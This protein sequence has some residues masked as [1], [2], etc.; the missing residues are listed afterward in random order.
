MLKSSSK[1]SI[2]LFSVTICGNGSWRLKRK[3][4]FN[5]IPINTARLL[6]FKKKTD[7]FSFSNAVPT[8]FKRCDSRIVTFPFGWHWKC[9][10][11]TAIQY[12][13]WTIGT[14]SMLNGNFRY[15]LAFTQRS[16]LKTLWPCSLCMS[17]FGAFK[18][19]FPSH[20]QR[21]AAQTN[22]SLLNI[23]FSAKMCDF[24]CLHWNASNSNFLKS[25]S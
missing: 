6:I 25:K 7:R 9:F 11:H 15:T 3:D 18:R 8:A 21:L 2:G 4:A 16:V 22:K 13:C 17:G 10:V 23:Y 12:T 20:Y 19:I 14:Y 1:Y 5:I 24:R